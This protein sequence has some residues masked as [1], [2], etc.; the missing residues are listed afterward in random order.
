MKSFFDKLNLR[1]QERRLVVIVGMVFFVV[2]NIWF[3]WPYFGQWSQV[4]DKMVKSRTTLKR[5]QDEIA[6]RSKYEATERQLSNIGELLVGELDMENTVRR[7]ATVTPGFQ[8]IDARTRSGGG[9]GSNTNRFFQEQIL[10]IQFNSGGKELIDFLVG[11]AS[12]NLL[13]RV[14]ELTVKP[15][16]PAP[17]RLTGSIVFVGNQQRRATNATNSASPSR[18]RT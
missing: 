11:I 4:E 15:A 14:R 7:Q 6:K 10:T 3:V 2:L 16:D 8:I 18:R 9:M 12:Q 13:M 5:Y 17:T 1:P